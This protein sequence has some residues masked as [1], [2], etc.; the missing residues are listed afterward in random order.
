MCKYYGIGCMLLFILATATVAAQNLLEVKHSPGAGQ[1]G[2]VGAALQAAVAG[3]IIE[4]IDNSAV[5][6]ENV[7]INQLPNMTLR[8][9][10]GLNPRPTIQGVA[11]TAHPL[12]DFFTNGATLVWNESDSLIVQDLIFTRGGADFTVDNRFSDN[13]DFTNCRFVATN[14]PLSC[15][16]SQRPATF[17][18]C[19]FLGA[20][21]ATVDHF[22]GGPLHLVGCTVDEGKSNGVIVSGGSVIIEDSFIGCQGLTTMLIQ[23]RDGEEPVQVTLNRSIVTFTERFQNNL[24]VVNDGGK[25]F[26]CSLSIDNC[27]IVG[28]LDRDPS[29]TGA[30]IITNEQTNLA[31][32]DT[33]FYNI[34]S[35][36]YALNGF[37]LGSGDEDYNAYKLAPNNLSDQGIEEGL[38]NLEL[39]DDAPLYNDPVNYDLRL[40]DG[41]AAL[42]LNSTGI[43]AWAGSQGPLTPPLNR[44]GHWTIY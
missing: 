8:G 28:S 30:G 26:G 10:A 4:V 37:N 40:V 19:A 33:I 29:P 38:N 14:A 42:T 17:T 12:D 44:A 15:M 11:G 32:T 7:Y 21:V 1:Y 25:E 2:S 41:S 36:A 34:S 22:F 6:A 43:P 5:F 23:D 24:I 3:D 39:A 31:V 27:D 20:N 13:G 9:K 18:D 35:V 16:R